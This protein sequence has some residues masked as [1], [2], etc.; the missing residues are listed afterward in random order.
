MRPRKLKAFD[1]QTSADLG[2]ITFEVNAYG[3]PICPHCGKVM[4]Y[5]EGQIDQDRQGNDIDGWNHVC[6]DCGIETEIMEG[7]GGYDG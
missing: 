2:E 6:Y 7:S 1:M 3:H 5:W 4:E